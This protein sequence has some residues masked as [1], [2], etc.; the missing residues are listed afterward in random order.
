MIKANNIKFADQSRGSHMIF[1]LRCLKGNYMILFLKGGGVK[2]FH[3]KKFDA[4]NNIIAITSI[5]PPP[6]PKKITLSMGADHSEGTK[7]K[8]KL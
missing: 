1:V 5:P 8:S 3:A 4:R 6:P 7:F 2:K